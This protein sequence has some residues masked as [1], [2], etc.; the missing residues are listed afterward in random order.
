MTEPIDFRRWTGPVENEFVQEWKAGGGKV[1]GYFCA[2]APEELLWAAGLLPIRMRGTGSTSTAC[3]DQY[4]GP[5]NCG[6]TRHTLDRLLNDELAWLDAL[7]LTNSCDHLRRLGDVCIATQRA[8]VCYSLDVPH[9]DTP[10]ALARLTA[11]LHA[12]KDRLA[13]F[14]AVS[15]TDAE[16]GAAI[17]LYNRS[18][19][20]LSRASQLRAGQPPRIT[21]SEILAMGV[22]AA[23]MPRDRFN[24]LMEERLAQ[25]ETA[26]AAPNGRRPRLLVIG[27]ALDDPA[28]LE[29]IESLG[30]H[31]VADHLCWGAKTFA[32]L[33]DETIEP[34]EAIARRMLGHLPCP[35]SLN[36][37]PQRFA[38]IAAAVAEYGVH[39]IVCERL[40]FCDLWGGE[41][42]MLRRSIREELQLPFLVLEREYLS[43]GSMGQLRT[44][45]QAFLETLG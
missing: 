42:E 38:S 11:Q 17:R 12:L 26:G 20:L 6:L 33:A 40:K 44:R 34:L 18:R 19:T 9:L 30:A 16:L 27:G 29:A 2:H 36:A 24:A 37:Y 41:V 23:S 7:L 5:V 43:A 22:A 15:I 45:V 39:G 10:A 31:V 14:F 3:A 13:S 35:R 4:F 32:N 1:A 25:L 21:G 28:Y 8:P